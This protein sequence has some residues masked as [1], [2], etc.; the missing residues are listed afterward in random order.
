MKEKIT[1]LL[2][3]S[4]IYVILVF[5][6]LASF[7]TGYFYRTMN[8]KNVECKTE[9]E[10]VKK[11]QVNLAIDQNNNLIMINLETGNYTIYE[12]S[13]GNTI[14]SLYAKNVW[15]QHTKISQ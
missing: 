14:F 8:T 13:I 15:G 11:G 9:V 10:R 2:K 5:A 4:V 12:D 6:C 1:E 3:K 7:A